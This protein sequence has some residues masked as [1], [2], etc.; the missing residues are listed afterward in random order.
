MLLGQVASQLGNKRLLIVGNGKL[1]LLPFG[2]LPNPESGLSGVEIQP[3]YPFQ[4]GFANDSAQGTGGRETQ[5][6]LANHE[7]INLPSATS[8]AIQRQT[9]ENRAPAP[10][11][12]AVIADPVFEHDD[13][14]FASNIKPEAIGEQDLRDEIGIDIATRS[15]CLGFDRL[16]NSGIEAQNILNI[17]PNAATFTATGFAANHQNTLNTPLEQYQFLHFATHGCIQDDAR[18]S[19]LALSRYQPDGELT[20]TAGLYLQDIYN[21]DLN[22]E[23]V[24]LSAC[25]TGIGADVVGEG[26][27]GMTSGFMYAGAKRVVFS[28]WKVDD[29]QTANLM[30]NLYQQLWTDERDPHQSL[31][32]AQLQM[33]LSDSKYRAPYYWAAFTMQGDF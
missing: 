18:L 21:L 15:G 9:W 14:R 31:R 2:A 6:L 8:L 26:V 27:V 12:V 24:V 30:S 13:P 7:I 11:T 5:P 16:P 17:A 3:P 33:W 28:L 1:Q 22:A 32:Q 25:E 20:P 4:G 29:A 23:L 19:H 10:K